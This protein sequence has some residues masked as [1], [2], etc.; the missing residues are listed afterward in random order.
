MKIAFKESTE[1]QLINPFTE[2]PLEDSKG[3]PMIAI[4]FGKH[5]P[6][7]KNA[8]NKLLK[9]SPKKAKN[10][11]DE[12]KFIEAQKQGLDLLCCCVGEFRDVNIETENG[13]LDPTDIRSMLEVEWIRS[14]IDTA[15]V[16]T[17]LFSADLKKT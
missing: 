1:L 16:E 13:Q 11:S 15:I 7:Y 12:E 17:A 8:L 6:R 2:E 3:K 9:G 4:V 14:Q 10:Q 5:T